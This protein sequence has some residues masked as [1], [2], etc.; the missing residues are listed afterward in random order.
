M[1]LMIRRLFCGL[2]PGRCIGERL[3]R[4]PFMIAQPKLV[5]HHSLP[6]DEELESDPAEPDQ[7]LIGFRA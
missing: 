2:T 3:D 1:P 6:S 7:V 5:G 4:R